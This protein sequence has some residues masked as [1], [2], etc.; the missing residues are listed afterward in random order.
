MFTHRKN[1][2]ILNMPELPEVHTTSKILNKLTK[3]RK[4]K[5]VWTDYNSP[6]YYGKENI[7][8]PKYFQKF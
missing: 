5:S 8:D 1:D 4:I 6:Y 3:G 7:K 2:T